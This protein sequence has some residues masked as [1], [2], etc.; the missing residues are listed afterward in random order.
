MPTSPLPECA[1]N[2]IFARLPSAPL[3]QLE[4]SLS[5]VHLDQGHSIA[6]AGQALDYVYFLS[7]GALVSLLAHSSNGSPVE[8]GVIGTEGVVGVSAVVDPPRS[9]HQALVQ[10]AGDAWRLPA[11]LFKTE[12]EKNPALQQAVLGFTCKLMGQISQTALCNRLHSAEERLAR[13]L[14]VSSEFAQS[15]DFTVTHEA[16][17]DLL[18]T[19]R[20]TV[21][22]TAAGLQRA[23]MIRYS[24]GTLKVV[25][26]RRLREIS[27]ECYEIIAR[28]YGETQEK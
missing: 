25:D 22:L 14:L 19:R 3:K 24:R 7:P 20:T 8:V 17:A 18:G 9:I 12:F 2:K 27:C 10:V 11:T 28:L 16:L 6:N 13:W 23:G 1:E 26:R 4:A 21:S 15:N 5:R